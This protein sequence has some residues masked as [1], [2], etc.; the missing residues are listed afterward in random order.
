M[1]EKNY[2]IN[3]HEEKWSALLEIMSR[4]R[5][6]NGC[7]WDREQTHDS[8]KRYL[9]EEAY[10]VLDAIDS[11]SAEKLADELGDLLLQVV[12][13]A[14]IA[15]EESRFDSDDVLDNINNKMIRRHPHVFAGQEAET[16]KDVLNQ[17]EI[18]KAAEGK[19]EIKKGL[20]DLNHNLPAL[21][22]AQKVQDKASRLGFDWETIDGPW[23]KLAEELEE[24]KRAQSQ[25]E[26]KE[27]LGDCLFALINL[28]RFMN[29]DSEDALRC[30]VKKFVSRF[31]HIEKRMI[32]EA[33]EW[34]NTSLEEMDKFWDEAKSLEVQ[35]KQEINK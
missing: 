26:R 2:A 4:L 20:M 17:W 31:Q 27:E 33:K 29:L 35:A 6:E 30:S 10:E 9:V 11:G 34:N 25:K 18:I 13:H 7:P 1:S 19:G 16:S 22:L 28:A 8:L 23:Q 15:K 3:I 14:Q 32:E 21:M 12:F 5:S 24:L